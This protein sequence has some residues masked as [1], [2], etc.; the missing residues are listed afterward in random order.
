M[1]DFHYNHHLYS[2]WLMQLPEKELSYVNNPPLPYKDGLP[3]TSL[4]QLLMKT[5]WSVPLQELFL[6][7]F[8]TKE[9]NIFQCGSLHWWIFF[10][11]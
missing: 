9:Q 1:K 8:K 11:K 6:Y 10:V 7:D 3:L 2:S 4:N 5:I